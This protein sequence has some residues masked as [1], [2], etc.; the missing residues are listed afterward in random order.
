[1]TMNL[2]DSVPKGADRSEVYATT[3]Q[4]R[5]FYTQLGDGYFT[6]LDTMN[7]M[8]HHMVVKMAR[9]GDHLLD[10][11]CGRGLL[12]PLLRYYKK[13]LGS[14]TGVD[15]KESNATFRKKKVHNNKPLTTGYYPFPVYFA[16]EDVAHMTDK[17]PKDHYDLIVYTSSIEHMHPDVGMKSLHEAYEVAAPGATMILTCPNTPEDQD[18]Y[19]TQYSHHVY[20]W[21]RSEIEPALREVGWVLADVFGLLINV[22][23]LREALTKT[24][25][26]AEAFEDQREYIPNEW[27]TP[28]YAFLFPEKAKELAYICTK[29]GTKW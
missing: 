11:C 2:V 24:P 1:M 19:D 5:N 20:E 10:M 8:Q 7:Y 9:K 18:G 6:T 13:D 15:I 25:A 4:M 23:E 21:K 3:G 17:L 16:H 28:I 22:T 12:L 27:L 26:L 29:G 14:Y